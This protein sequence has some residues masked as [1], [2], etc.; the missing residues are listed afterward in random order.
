MSTK[1]KPE[2]ALDAALRMK[3]LVAKDGPVLNPRLMPGTIEG[4]TEDTSSLAG[5][6]PGAK[7]ARQLKKAAT[8]TVEQT[9]SK[10]LQTAQGI[11]NL[12]RL[13]KLS[14]DIRIAVGVGQPM[15]ARSI[16]SVI[17]GAEMIIAAYARYSTALREAGVLPADIELISEL[18]NRL[19]TDNETQEVQKVT[20]KDMTAARNAAHQRIEDAIGRIQAAAELA[21]LNNPERLAMYRAVVPS[22]PSAKKPAAPQA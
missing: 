1:M 22:K 4:L 16:K 21:F 2:V 18:R 12:C 15:Q 7:T 3:E 11:R 14:D 9:A 5:N 6:A 10:L 13:A 19:A 8:S 20:A 17:N